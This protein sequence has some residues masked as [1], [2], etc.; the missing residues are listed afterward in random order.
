MRSASSCCSVRMR[1]HV[2]K[3]RQVKCLRWQREGRAT[4]ASGDRRTLDAW[5]AGTGC[6]A[7]FA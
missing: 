1:L 2:S 4:L 7:L 3:E 5:L 6:E